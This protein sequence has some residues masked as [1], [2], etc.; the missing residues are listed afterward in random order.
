M[1][2]YWKKNITVPR[3]LII[4][5][6]INDTAYDRSD[7]VIIMT[8]AAISW[9]HDIARRDY[10]LSFQRLFSDLNVFF[11]PELRWRMSTANR[12]RLGSTSS[13][14]NLFIFAYDNRET[15]RSCRYRLP[16]SNQLP[17]NF[18]LSSERAFISIWMG[19]S[20][21]RLFSLLSLSCHVLFS[22]VL[23]TSH[24]SHPLLVGCDS[25]Q[26]LVHGG[27][28]KNSDGGWQS[29]PREVGNYI[30]QGCLADQSMFPLQLSD[31]GPKIEKAYL[32][33]RA[34][35]P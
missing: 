6:I 28:Q 10:N 20:I 16:E 7:E 32:S 2:I 14:N 5:M 27:S 21:T 31:N 11:V 33:L 4:R 22:F 26:Q 17:T 23:V 25:D 15:D 35:L 9:V 12:V 1:C 19:Q 34:V 30:F 3:C 13:D 18:W 29:R 24:Y 8:L